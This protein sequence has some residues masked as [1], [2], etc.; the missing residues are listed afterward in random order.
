ISNHFGKGEEDTGKYDTPRE[1]DYVM[2]AAI[3]VR[4]GLFEQLGGFDE[5]FFPAYYE[6]ADLCAQLHRLGY[7]IVYVPAALLDHHEAVTLGPA[8]RRFRRLYHR[9][10]LRYVLKNFGPRQLLPA[11]QYELGWLPRSLHQLPELIGAYF[12]AA[13]WALGKKLKGKPIRHR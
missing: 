9:M 5:D 8:T 10:R 3:A 13:R 12:N 11:L 1:V 2:G 6:E 7:K 4:R